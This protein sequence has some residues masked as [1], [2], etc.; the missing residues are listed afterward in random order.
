MKK[1]DKWGS[2][3][4]LCYPQL[5]KKTSRLLKA[6]LKFHYFVFFQFNSFNIFTVNNM[7]MFTVNDHDPSLL[8]S[9]YFDRSCQKNWLHHRVGAKW[10]SVWPP[11]TSRL[12]HHHGGRKLPFRHNHHLQ[13]TQANQV[14][15]MYVNL[16]YPHPIE[17]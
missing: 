2:R 8:V 10:W 6:C 14:T 3:P 11:S 15:I 9:T 12:N 5:K 7:Y 13:W 16:K 1:N 4:Q 17:W